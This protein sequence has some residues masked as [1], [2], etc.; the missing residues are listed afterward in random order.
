MLLPRLEQARKVFAP[1][2]DAIA[3]SPSEQAAK[4]Y[5]DTLVFDAPT[6]RHLVDRFG[7]SQLMIGTD[8]PFAFHDSRPVQSILDAGFD[9]PTAE[10]LIHGNARRFLNMGANH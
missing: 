2:R 4:L 6:L 8:Y 1:L 10:L 3:S 5:Y 7:P 9:A